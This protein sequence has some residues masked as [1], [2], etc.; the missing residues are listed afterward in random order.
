MKQGPT[1]ARIK[2]AG[3]CTRAR[4]T[5]VFFT[6]FHTNS[7]GSGA[8]EYRGKKNTCSTSNWRYMLRNISGRFPVHLTSGVR[9]LPRTDR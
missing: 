2:S 1:T 6:S 7:S 5:P 9:P 4:P 8:G 3:P